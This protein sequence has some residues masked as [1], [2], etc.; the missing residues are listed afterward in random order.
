[1]SISS[2]TYVLY[3][4]VSFL[5]SACHCYKQ[6]FV[7][8]SF[9]CGFKVLCFKY[10]QKSCVQCSFRLLIYYIFFSWHNIKLC[11][12]TYSNEL[13]MLVNKHFLASLC[14][15]GKYCVLIPLWYASSQAGG[16]QC[17][18]LRSRRSSDWGNISWYFNKYPRI[19]QI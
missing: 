17:R 19:G 18:R 16:W 7:C 4:L 5:V 9:I 6:A 3:A 12:N 13:K 2:L 15:L 1:M 10:L 8:F 14:I 11:W